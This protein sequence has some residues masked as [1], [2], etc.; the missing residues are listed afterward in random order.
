MNAPAAK[1]SR[2]ARE[3]TDERSGRKAE[4]LREGIDLPGHSVQPVGNRTADT[5]LEIVQMG[6]FRGVGI[7]EQVRQGRGCFHGPVRHEVRDVEIAV[8]ADGSHDRRRTGGDGHR[9]VIVVKAGQVHLR[10]AAAQD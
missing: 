6:V 4:P 2:C 10:T 5:Q 3:S 8:V 7:Q 1:R 9:Q